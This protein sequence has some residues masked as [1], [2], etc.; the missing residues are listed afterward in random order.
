MRLP[1]LVWM[2][3]LLCAGAPTHAGDAASTPRSGSAIYVVYHFDAGLEQAK[4]GLRNIRNHLNADPD[5]RIVVVGLAEGIDFMLKGAKT[6]GGYPFQIMVEEL[7][8]DGV[9][10]KI[11]NNTLVARHVDPKQVLDDVEIVDSGVA[12]LA[13]LQIREGYAYIKP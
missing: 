5:A 10:F 4:R 1:M 12:E 13:R 9:R 11:C 8:A 7:Q 3:A 2:V 6:D